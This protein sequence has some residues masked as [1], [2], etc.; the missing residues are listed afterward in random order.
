MITEWCNQ[1]R[2]KRVHCD[3][4]LLIGS[5]DFCISDIRSIMYRDDFTSLPLSP[6][7]IKCLEGFVLTV[8]S[9][10]S[11][12][13]VLFTYTSTK[14]SLYLKV[15]HGLFYYSFMNIWHLKWDLQYLTKTAFWVLQCW[16]EPVPCHVIL[17]WVTLAN[18]KSWLK[19]A[20]SVLDVMSWMHIVSSAQNY[21]YFHSLVR[22]TKRVKKGMILHPLTV[23]PYSFYICHCF[24]SAK[25]KGTCICIKYKSLC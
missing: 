23:I 17:L 16:F 9:K 21:K 25:K 13:N 19:T 5:S 11:I 2:S 20:S 24:N 22:N 12:V 4:E 15:W 3:H 6:R 18:E 7:Q 10:C 14:G 8:L 1:P